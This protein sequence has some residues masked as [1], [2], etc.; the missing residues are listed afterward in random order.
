MIVSMT[1][2][3]VHCIIVAP[4]LKILICTVFSYDCKVLS[5]CYMLHVPEV[6][7]NIND[8]N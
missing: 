4:I 3:I 2:D 6:G 7:V 5:S 1:R 8:I